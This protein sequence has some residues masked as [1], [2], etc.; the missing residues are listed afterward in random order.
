M[1]NDAADLLEQA[2][3]L[4]AAARAALADSLVESLDDELDE[5]A[6]DAWRAEIARRVE[7]LSSGAVQAVSWDET[8]RR[9]RARFP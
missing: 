8:R 2:L 3:K 5:D 1:A 7:E 4:P 9:L 6:E